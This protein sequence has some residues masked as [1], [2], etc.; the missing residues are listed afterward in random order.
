MEIAR[1]RTFT[2]P[3][4][5]TPASALRREKNGVGGGGG[6]EGDEENRGFMINDIRAST[7]DL[8]VAS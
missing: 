1:K 6:G 7:Q 8:L 3:A 2:P 5:E 4:T